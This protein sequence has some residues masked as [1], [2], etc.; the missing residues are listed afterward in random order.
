MCS[1]HPPPFPPPSPPPPHPSYGAIVLGIDCAP[2]GAGASPPPPPPVGAT[3]GVKYSPTAFKNLAG[4]LVANDCN[5]ANLGTCM[6][7]CSANAACM[8]FNVKNGCCDLKKWE[9]AEVP[10]WPDSTAT[11]GDGYMS[12]YVTER[13]VIQPR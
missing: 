3:G 1:T 5:N 11:T 7:S 2:D 4:D 9:G 6:A 10:Y 8:G 12:Q 13:P